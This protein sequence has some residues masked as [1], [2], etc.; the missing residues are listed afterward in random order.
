MRIPRQYHVVFTRQF[1]RGNR[2]HG[3]PFSDDQL[4]RNSLLLNLHADTGCDRLAHV[5]NSEAGK[6]GERIHLLDGHWLGWH[7]ANQASV[8]SHKERWVG[9]LPALEVF[10]KSST[11]ELRPERCVRGTQ[12]CNQLLRLG[13]VHQLNLTDEGF[14]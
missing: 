13:D 12:V 6:F 10:S 7:E 14:V 4:V 11:N 2:W 8:T 9:F 1:N 5:A 3:H